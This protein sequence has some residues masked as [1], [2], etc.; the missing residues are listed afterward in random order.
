MSKIRNRNF[1]V[2][3]V[4][5]A[6]T[7][8]QINTHAEESVNLPLN[9]KEE[10]KNQTEEL[11]K[12]LKSLEPPIPIHM[13]ELPFEA[14]LKKLYPSQTVPIRDVIDKGKKISFSVI[15]NLP[16]YKRPVYEEHWHSTYWGGRW[17]YIPSRIYYA[18]HRVF[19]NY[20]IGLSGWMNFE[21]DMGF[22]IEMYQNET[23]LDMYIVVFQTEVIAV[24]TRGNQVVVVG[25]PKRNGVVVI[26]IKTGDLLPADTKE[27]LLVQLATQ[28]GHE[29]DYSLIHYEPPDF[30]LK[31][32]EKHK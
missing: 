3:S 27:L 32:K 12:R 11:E 15:K 8:C 25:N 26:T 20:D 30:W 28:S 17:S 14:N 13:D 23:A 6:S 4:L 22:S 31:Q 29:L 9:N 10:S 2:F 19:T 1:L 18:S 24:Y 16:D 7:L 21:K 5:L